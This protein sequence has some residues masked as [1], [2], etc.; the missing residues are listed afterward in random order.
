M[1]GDDRIR[2][3]KAGRELFDELLSLVKTEFPCAN[4][5]FQE[6]FWSAAKKQAESALT[7]LGISQPKAI[8]PVR[9][10]VAE[11]EPDCMTAAECAAF[12]R[13]RVPTVFKKHGGKTV[14]QVM[15]SDPGYFEFI[16]TPTE[17]DEWKDDLVR[18]LAA[19]DIEIRSDGDE[20]E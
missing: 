7:A 6:A 16:T 9:V 8:A 1:E 4:R 14:L 17:I 12:E 19:Q 13:Q 20:D 10:P 2:N 5:D 18:Y 11:V 3:R 15:G